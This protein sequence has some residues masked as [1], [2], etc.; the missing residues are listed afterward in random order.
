MSPLIFTLFAASVI[1]G[2]S[3]VLASSNWFF[4]WLG[5]EINT[6]AF[7]PL[8]VHTHQPRATE[9]AVNYFLVQALASTL[10]LFGGLIQALLSNSWDINTNML[11]LTLTLLI[12]AVTLNMAIA[13]FHSWLVDVLQGVPFQTGLILTTWQ[14]IAP[15][16]ILLTLPNQPIWVFF[17]LGL[18]S[19][20]LGSLGGL[21]QTQIRNLLAYSAIAHIG[22][23]FTAY[24]ISSQISTLALFI[25]FLIASTVF[26]TFNL[27]NSLNL[28][29]LSNIIHIAPWLT[30][31][32]LL[33]VLS[34]SGLPPLTGFLINWLIILTLALN[35]S[36]IA[37]TIL[38]SAS[39]ISLF[40]YLRLNYLIVMSLSP[41]HTTATLT[42]R[43]IQQTQLTNPILAP[44]ITI[45]LLGTA[46]PSMWVSL[47]S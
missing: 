29:D 30:A 46:L 23:I 21:N 15:F 6:L 39:L 34:L 11:P 1:I 38:V 9:A 26:I 31:L 45:S 10:L 12:S 42:W 4:I 17:S 24:P 3:I 2:T 40:F 16:S 35:S 43:T 20:I 25:Y 32:T 7:L 18:L 28:A 13:P 47:F 14:N 8:L 5:L 19:A 33:V 37:A 27:L 44:L 36:L 22:W 41:Q